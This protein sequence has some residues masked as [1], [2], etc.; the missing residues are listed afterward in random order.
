MYFFA[1][2]ILLLFINI[3]IY[4]K[5]LNKTKMNTIDENI[6]NFINE[7][8]NN[9]NYVAF[10][11]ILKINEQNLNNNT[12]NDNITISP[13]NNQHEYPIIKKYPIQTHHSIQYNENEIEIFTID[14]N[15]PCFCFVILFYFTL[16]CPIFFFAILCQ[17][18]YF[19][20]TIAE[21]AY[22]YKKGRQIIIKRRPINAC[23]CLYCGISDTYNIEDINKFDVI[24]QKSKYIFKVIDNNGYEKIILNIGIISEEVCYQILEFLNSLLDN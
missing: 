16:F 23:Y 8:N 5:T 13:T 6:S 17:N 10:G 21:R 15:V 24:K 3:I 1:K 11:S 7:N 22:I 2:D 4:L 14:D 12:K 19:K 20:E 9:T 18:T